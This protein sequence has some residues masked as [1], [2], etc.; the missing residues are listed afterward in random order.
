MSND[1]KPLRTYRLKNEIQIKSYVHPAR[2]NIL[3][4]LAREKRTITGVAEE[5]GVHPANITH[6]FKNLEKS[7]LIKI[8]EKRDIGRNIE[9]YYRAIAYSFSVRIS[10]EMKINKE[11]LALSILRDDMSAAVE[12]LK[13]SSPEADTVRAYITSARIDRKQFEVFSKKLEK[14]LKDFRA[15]GHARGAATTINLSIYPNDTDSIPEDEEVII[16]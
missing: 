3:K 16:R 6:H 1:I 13:N 11:A 7:G 9:K 14:L 10:K 8:V 5:I 4:M 15:S 12:T 2:L